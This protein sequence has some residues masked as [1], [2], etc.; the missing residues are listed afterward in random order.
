M[1]ERSGVAPHQI[2][3]MSRKR[4]AGTSDRALPFVLWAALARR[5]NHQPDLLLE[6]CG[7]IRAAT[8]LAHP[9]GGG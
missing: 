8:V 7:G 9:T 6:F 3:R 5:R 1:A 2:V 4:I